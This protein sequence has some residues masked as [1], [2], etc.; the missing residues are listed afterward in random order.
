M[1]WA[2]GLRQPGGRGIEVPGVF[3]L[4]ALFLTSCVI[5]PVP[6]RAQKPAAEP[7]PTTTIRFTDITAASGIHF[8]HAISP[9]KKYLAESMSG[10]VLLLDYDQD[11]WLDI[12]F[13]NAPSVEM[14]LHGQKAKSALYHNN[15]DGTFTDV[16]DKAGVG[17]P[18]WAIGGA[19]ADYNNDGWPD[20]LVTCE[21]GMVLYRNNGDGTFTDVTK[22]AHLTDPR[23]T[24][25]AAFADYDGDGFPDLMVSRY[26]VFDLN[27]LPQFG[28]GPT[29]HFRGIPVQCGPR[30]MKGLADSLYHNNGD[31]TF[32][33]VSKS[34]GVDDPSAYYGLGVLWADF[35]DDGRPD[36]F[37]ADDSTPNY[38]YR[39]DGNGH[40]TDV[41]FVSGTAVNNDGG[42]MAGMGVAACDYN[43]TGRL[44]LVVT[45]FEEQ[46][47]TLYRN[48]GGMTFNEVSNGAGIS[49]I[50]TR[51]LGWGIGCVDF[52]NDSWDDLFIVNGHVYP[53]VDTYEAGAKYR[54]RKLLFQNQR[55]GTFREVSDQTGPALSIPQ[56][57]RGAAFGDLNNDGKIDVVVEN[58]DGA[59]MILRNDSGNGNH[60]IT[61]Q[62]V[63][64]RSNRLAIGARV[65][66][67][68]GSLVQI[69]EVH[70]GG[71]YLSQ[72]DMRIHFGL[73]DAAKV[74]RV[75]IRWPSGQTETLQN[76]AGD[77][78]YVIKE[79]VGVV[80]A[81]SARPTGAKAASAGT[82]N[83]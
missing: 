64:T 29:C 22:E 36:L 31:G 47:E 82:K 41:G 2:R 49:A 75:E 59:P 38:L 35:N 19:V 62:L 60:W 40:F 43:H 5:L 79:G 18:C 56:A 34:A 66:A 21:E 42:E 28:S 27:H 61:L 33:D 9:E 63:G 14:A 74:D 58:I 7:K 12:Y 25:G 57:S 32:T 81:E 10:G 24:T 13:T 46:G 73:G 68:A 54:E 70:S 23:W 8:E 76:L 77:R 39:N 16:S 15:H 1:F 52:D 44:S 3:L 72:S 26:V 30:G 50:T 69:D 20:I 6:L 71:S 48:D 11:G 80:P 78:F 37:V 65:K 55:D 17:Y 51:Y 4:L 53:Q 83:H 67:I 45:N